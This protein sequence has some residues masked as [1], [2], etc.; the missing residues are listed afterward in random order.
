MQIDTIFNVGEVVYICKNKTKREKESCKICDGIGVISIK[1]KTFDCPEC[2]GNKTVRV[3]SVRNFVPE[4]RIITKVIV[5]ITENNEKIQI[6]RRYDCKAFTRREECNSITGYNNLIFA[7]LEEAE[8]RCK[9]M[10]SEIFDKVQVMDCKNE[11]VTE[12]P[13]A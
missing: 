6:Y 2:H 12:L 5:S 3:K 10:N 13:V 4:R 7:T 11:V 8:A 9:E 1:D